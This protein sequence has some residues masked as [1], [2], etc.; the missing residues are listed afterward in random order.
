MAFT[1][2]MRIRDVLSV[3]V[4]SAT[5]FGILEGIVLC[6][7]RAYP[8]INAS[9]KVPIEALWAS[10]LIDT[11]FFV[12]AAVGLLGVARIASR[13]RAGVEAPL[14]AGGLLWFGYTIV[15]ST[16][17]VM[18][19]AS[20]ALLSLGLAVGTWRAIQGRFERLCATL[21][22]WLPIVP[23]ALIALAGGVAGFQSVREARAAGVLTAASPGERNVLVVV[24]DTVR[25]DRFARG[26]EATLTPNLDR[27]AAR[28][29]RFE[30]AWSTSS[31]SLP[32]Q[33]SILTGRDP[34]EHG[35]DWP[36][37]ALD[38]AVPTLGQFFTS[39]GYV[40]GAFSANPSWATPEYLGPGFLRFD[41][42]TAEDVLRRTTL[43]R[44][45]NRA[46]RSLGYADGGRAKEAA[47]VN[48]EF[49][50]LLDDYPDRP[51]FAYLCYMDANAAVYDRK[52]NTY[53]RQ[54]APMEEVAD[55]YDAGLRRL[56][57]SI[58]ALFDELERRGALENTI[59]VVTSDHGES[60]PGVGDDHA[61]EGHGTSLYPEQVRVPLF[62][63]A[64][65]LV[66][67]GG[68]VRDVVST[69][70]I[71]RTVVSLIG[72]ADAPFPGHLLPLP[73]DGSR[74]DD[75]PPALASLRYG[76]ADVESVARDRW[77]YIVRNDAE[78]PKEE[79]YDIVQDP[80]ARTPV[81]TPEPSLAPFRD[82]VK[83]VDGSR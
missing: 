71:A 77:Y 44:R 31:W 51:F 28:G 42:Y 66:P 64:P 80:T 76:D 15:I 35:A 4:W 62:V 5:V 65:G 38:P 20:A 56:D 6:V 16:P 14:I 17:A 60:F 41:V 67:S 46:L 21:V 54:Q 83:A 29:V 10:P 3:A 36:E 30:N 70:A 22:R 74:S 73:N 53:F 11:P 12:A 48:A 8:A 26:P 40:T 81:E 9:R 7:C 1:P 75:A 79:M 47:Q 45:I 57:A 24:M 39:R 61:E 58:G 78:A 19:D 50:N 32:A 43:G 23:L 82:I 55:S 33:V 59:V 37:F 27:R 49:L 2:S 68:T 63:I 34:H 69:R 25:Y 72:A 13:F 52:Y 18:Q